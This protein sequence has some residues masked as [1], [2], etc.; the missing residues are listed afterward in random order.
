[1]FRAGRRRRALLALLPYSRVRATDVAGCRTEIHVSR[2]TARGEAPEGSCHTARRSG[3]AADHLHAAIWQGPR[4]LYC[5]G[6][7]CHETKMSADSSTPRPVWPWGKPLPRFRSPE[8]EQPFWAT[9]DV[10]GPPPEVGD[11]VLSEQSRSVT[12]ARPI[13]WAGWAGLGGA[14]GAVIGSFFGLAGAAV[15]GGV[16]AGMA[17][18]VLAMRSGDEQRFS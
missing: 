9:H 13:S 16:G 17:A 4:H 10:E 6:R 11:V 12:R 18:Y 2:S 8:E 7:C 5:V 3:L 1:M 14:I 15:G